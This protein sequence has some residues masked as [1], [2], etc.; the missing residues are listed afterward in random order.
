MNIIYLEDVDVKNLQCCFDDGCCDSSR[1]VAF[2]CYDGDF[3]HPFPIT[4]PN[5]H[6]FSAF[7]VC[8][9][10][11]RQGLDAGY[12]TVSKSYFKKIY[13][14]LNGK[15]K[16]VDNIFIKFQHLLEK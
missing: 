5:K 15:S 1:Y 12:D 11:I 6:R 3:N 4:K 16:I 7:T 9:N 8:K 14:K 10:H 2:C 13:I